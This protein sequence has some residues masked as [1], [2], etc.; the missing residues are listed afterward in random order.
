MPVDFF[1]EGFDV[2]PLPIRSPVSLPD[3]LPVLPPLENTNRETVE[4]YAR[5][6]LDAFGL[7]EWAF[8]W[9]KARRRLGRCSY[10]KKLITLSIH[11]A[12]LNG[13]EEVMETIRHEVGHAVVGPGHGH[14]PVWRAAAR[15]I[16]AKPVR[17]STTAKV[18]AGTWQATCGG[19]SRI[20]HRYRRPKRLDGWFC[21]RCGRTNGRLIWLRKENLP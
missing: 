15:R 17:C 16:G 4:E 10:R 7:A 21:R 9:D 1:Y 11:L 5:L 12:A 3:P 13:C 2:I 20:S 18:P 19:C 8:G 14:G 6:V